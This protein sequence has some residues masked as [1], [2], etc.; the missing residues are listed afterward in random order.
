[1]RAITPN[2]TV[3][4]IAGIAGQINAAGQYPFTWQTP[5]GFPST[6]EYWSGNMLPRWNAASYV[7]AQNAPASIQFNVT[8]FMTP[9]TPAAIVSQI[10]K[11]I[12]AGEM[13]QQVRD[14]LTKY[15]TTTP[16]STTRVRETIALAM[17]SSPF[18]Y[19]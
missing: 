9:A 11:Y 15:V 17:A 6:L 18:Q 7:S 5:D 1:L 14:E 16:T 19:F 13:T 2:V 12:F 8:P 3:Q 4:N 10:D